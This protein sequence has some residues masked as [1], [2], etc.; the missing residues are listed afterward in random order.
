MKKIIFI[1]LLSIVFVSC[2]SKVSCDSSKVK[3][4]AL[5]L[6]ETEIRVQLAWG[7]YYDEVI[8]PIENTY[9]GALLQFYAYAAGDTSFDIEKVKE[10]TILSFR[11]LAKGKTVEDAEKYQSYIRYADSI[12]DLGKISLEIIMTT[13]NHPE[14]K[15]CECEAT[16]VFDPEINIE[17]MDVNYDVQEASDGE[18][19]V[20]IYMR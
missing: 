6:F 13:T 8:S 10:E 7:V 1:I 2:N 12:M 9:G 16:L 19:Y 4:T 20:T 5:R 15:K 11:K 17:D 18:V 14:L 3:E